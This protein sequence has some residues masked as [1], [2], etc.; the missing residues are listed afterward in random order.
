MHLNMTGT[1]TTNYILE[2]TTDLAN[3]S[4][5][6]ILSGSDGSFQWVDL[7][8]TNDSRRFYRLRLDP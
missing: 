7:C 1:P 4:N 6:C 3:W 5:A 8:A 2:W